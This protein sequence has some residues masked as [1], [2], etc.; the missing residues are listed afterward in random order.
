MGTDPFEEFEFKPLTDGL[1]FHKKPA[2]N[3]SASSPA[4]FTMAPTAAPVSKTSSDMGSRGID[5]SDEADINN[6]FKDP[7][8]RRENKSK[9]KTAAAFDIPAPATSPVDDILNTLHQNRKMEIEL[10][11]RHRNELR[12]PKATTTL[13]VAA[14]R[15]SPMILDGMLVMAA[16][17]LCMIIMLVVTRVDLLSNL[18]QPDTEGLVY[19][20]TFSLFAAVSFIYMVINRVFLGFTPGEWAYDLRLGKVEQLGTGSYALRAIARQVLITVTGLF[21]LPLIGWLMGK[22]LAGAATGL[23]LMRK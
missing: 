21:P 23:P 17:L 2:T 11:R 1:G 7:L 6:P 16:G 18:S 3:N 15:L 12:N 9:T 8:P 20:A 19:L 14:P 5:F 4:S 13:K 22:D 10:D